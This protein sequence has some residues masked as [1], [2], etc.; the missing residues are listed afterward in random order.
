MLRKGMLNIFTA[1]VLIPALCP[2]SSYGYRL[3]PYVLPRFDPK[4]QNSIQRYVYGYQIKDEYGTIQFRKE[5]TTGDRAVK[6]SYGYTDAS[7]MYR[8][9]EYVA[10]ADGFRAII[11]TN[12]P[13]TAS[14]NSADV[15]IT[16]E[17][18]RRL[19]ASALKENNGSNVKRGPLIG[20][21]LLPYRLSAYNS[22]YEPDS[23]S[24]LT[25]TETPST[26]TEESEERTEKSK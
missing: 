11:K 8:K 23:A 24:L 22:P 20:Y 10:D 19:T 17:Y 18:G 12:E 16:S 15:K 14:R 5:E 7:G 13:G 2:E 9:V 21:Q 4:I 3:F 26:T 25:T 6:G 1:L